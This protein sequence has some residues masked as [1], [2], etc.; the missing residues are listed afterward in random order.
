MAINTIAAVFSPGTANAIESPPTAASDAFPVPRKIA[1]PEGADFSSDAAFGYQVA[2][3][4]NTLLVS[5]PYEDLTEV[6]GFSNGDEGVVWIYQRQGT[7][8]SRTGRI[9]SSSPDF[10][11]YFG[12]SIALDGNT[13][14][15]GSTGEQAQVFV[16]SGNDWS[17][18]QR[19]TIT[20]GRFNDQ[21]GRDE[22]ALDGNTA[23]IGSRISDVNGGTDQG[24]AYVFV[25][26]GTS[27]AQE[28]KL[29]AS[30]GANGDRFGDE[31]AIQGDTLFI[32]APGA[33]VD[34]EPDF[35]AVYVFTRD[36]GRWTE[37][38]KLLPSLGAFG[39]L[40]GLDI[41]VDGETA[42]I[43]QADRVFVFTKVAGAWVETQTF[44]PSDPQF[45]DFFGNSIALKGDIAVIGSFG[46][47]IGPVRGQGAAYV[48]QNINGFWTQTQ[49]FF[50]PD[51]GEFGYFGW[52]V[53]FDGDGLVIG[54]TGDSL[55]DESTGSVFIS[56]LGTVF[57]SGFE[58]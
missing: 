24:A 10:A 7:G 12:E 17:F 3:Q 14:I 49:R 35:G 38:Q 56:T 1:A 39:R 28:Q 34:G 20:D 37:Q 22:N 6:T 33:D 47:D 8:W 27:W 23:V 26:D 51:G 45:L 48:F 29:F 11:D 15:V 30:D 36:G 13:L 57:A 16:G 32:G 21:F 53:S 44:I 52:H 9:T 54:A 19:L 2:L 5:A 4:G 58:D 40:F 43:S 18:Q 25:R 50:D 41:A 31:I 55:N 46:K 42:M